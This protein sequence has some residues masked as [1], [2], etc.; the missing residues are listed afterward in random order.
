MTTEA[1]AII[2][3]EPA[4]IT[5]LDNNRLTTGSGADVIAAMNDLKAIRTFINEELVETVDFGV[6]PGTGNKKNLLLPGAQKVCMFLNAYPVYHVEK[7]DIDERGHVEFSVS[8]NL[9]SRASGHVI[10]S[11]VGS[12]T[13][14][15]G[16][17]RFREGGRVCPQCG[18]AA[19]INGKA[20]YVKANGD[21]AFICFQKKGGCNAK[22]N[23]NDTSITAQQV[24]K[25]ENENVWDVRN[26]VLK[27]AKK[28]SV[29]DASIGLACLSEFFTQ[30]MDDLV[31]FNI[32]AQPENTGVGAAP[33][34]PTQPRA[35][36]SQPVEVAPT[37][38]V[39][40]TRLA[41]GVSRSKPNAS[42]K[43]VAVADPDGVVYRFHGDVLIA[44]AESYV[45]APDIA[46]LTYVQDDGFRRVTFAEAYVEVAEVVGE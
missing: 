10:G 33:M 16:K 40:Q 30:D 12:C 36:A 35:A 34:S 20:E 14:M 15:E 17:Y 8:T 41:K 2:D 32:E 4:H 26:T 23:K 39:V 27:M 6:I 22:F 25:V 11:G 28:R 19:I 42:P 1:L 5:R 13:T 21:G 18:A 44:F 29:V 38:A 7:T 9:V 24:G 43:Y 45:G 37:P 46:E 31:T 3:T